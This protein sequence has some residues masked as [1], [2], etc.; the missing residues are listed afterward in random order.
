MK[1]GSSPNTGTVTFDISGVRLVA[2]GL[3]SA[4][5]HTKNPIDITSYKKLIVTVSALTSVGGKSV[6]VYV[7]KSSS[8]DP[9]GFTGAKIESISSNGDKELDISSLTG[10]YYVVL[11]VANDRAATVNKVKLQ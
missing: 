9:D 2:V 3:Q 11:A 8:G 1:Y 6:R 4:I 5:V 10:D 7:T